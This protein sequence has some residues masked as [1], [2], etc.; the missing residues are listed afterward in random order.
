MTDARTPEVIDGVLCT[1]GHFNDPRTLYCSVC[2]ISMLQQTA[3]IVR[4]PRPPLGVLVWDDGAST[5]VDS[6]MV[7][8]REPGV[9]PLVTDAGLAPHVVDDP[10]IE[11]SRVHLA[12][13]PSG[14]D[15]TVVDLGSSNGTSIVRG[16]TGSVEALRP[17]QPVVLRDSDTVRFGSRSF[18]F[19]SHHRV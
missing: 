7:M 9:H 4:R 17:E 3:R 15:V 5:S 8:G 11:S 6:G 16:S 19:R 18:V 1:A 10:T 12:V 2:G 13:R 14:W